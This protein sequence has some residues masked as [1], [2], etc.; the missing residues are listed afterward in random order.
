MEYI[1][2]GTED[3]EYFVNTMDRSDDVPKEDWKLTIKINGK[4]TSFKL[5]I[6]VQ[7]NLIPMDSYKKM[8][9]KPRLHETKAQR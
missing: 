7:V 5:D 9:P 4:Y 8:K 1:D 2:V 6:W 3:E